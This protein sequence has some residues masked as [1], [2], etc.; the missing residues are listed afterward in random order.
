MDALKVPETRFGGSGLVLAGSSSVHL[1]RVLAVSAP[2]RAGGVALPLRR[3]ERG[4]DPRLASRAGGEDPPLA[5]VAT[6][7]TLDVS[8]PAAGTARNGRWRPRVDRAAGAGEP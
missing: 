1:M 2:A 5:T 6:R 4:G 7:A 8:A 3:R